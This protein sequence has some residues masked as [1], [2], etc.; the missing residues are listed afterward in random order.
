M[1][2]LRITTVRHGIEKSRALLKHYLHAGRFG[3]PY[4]PRGIAPDLVS[5]FI[6]EEIRPDTSR[7]VYAKAVELMRFYERQ[8]VVDHLGLALLRREK[9]FVDLMRSTHA[10]RAAGDLG[11]DEQ[12]AK[13]AAYH[14]TVI[15]PHPVADRIYDALAD[16]TVVLAP[17]GTTD[18]IKARVQRDLKR[19]EPNQDQSE[20]DMA[21]YDAVLEVHEQAIPG[22]DSTIDAKKK[23]I[24][25]KPPERAKELVDIYLG[26]GEPSDPYMQQW[27]ARQIRF[28][29]AAT[30]FDLH[31]PR[32]IEIIDTLPERAKQDELDQT[33]SDLLLVRSMNAIAYF[34]AAPRIEHLELFVKA[35]RR[36]GI[37][38]NFLCDEDE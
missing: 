10:I 2:T 25:Q 12:R 29:V 17:T 15:I 21:A 5:L 16:T 7:H 26:L 6:R 35:K 18:A 32:F 24:V 37:H 31:R 28:D 11:T 3:S 14:D 19:L 27:A 1:G 34:H 23:L 13:A 4:V 9:D 22:A 20:E 8:D 38:M 30:S 36:G 33:E